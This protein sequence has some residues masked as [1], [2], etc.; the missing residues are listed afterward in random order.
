VD[1]VVSAP[2]LDVVDPVGLD[3]RAEALERVRAVSDQGVVE[4]AA[5]DVL[6]V[7]ADTVVLARRPIVPGAVALPRLGDASASDGR[8]YDCRRAIRRPAIP[9]RLVV[10]LAT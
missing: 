8:E 4:I 6:D 9:A 10:L 2:A 3:L 1:C 7:L 5:D